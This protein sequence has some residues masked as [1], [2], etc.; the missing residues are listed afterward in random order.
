MINP[1][2]IRWIGII[3]LMASP[4]A[5]YLL[6]DKPYTRTFIGY[7]KAGRPMFSEPCCEPD[8]DPAR[9]GYVHADWCKG[10]FKIE[11]RAT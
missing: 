5:F 7:D 1:E 10:E 8:Y 4:F 9:G 6:R 11:K 3:I 2:L